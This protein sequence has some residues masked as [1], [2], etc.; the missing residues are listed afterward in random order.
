[1]PHPL[2]IIHGHDWTKL[3]KHIKDTIALLAIKEG[4]SDTEVE[5]L[6]EMYVTNI[7]DNHDNIFLASAVGIVQYLNFYNVFPT[8]GV[9]DE[10]KG[11]YFTG[12]A[13]SEHLEKLGLA[14]LNKFHLRAVL[15]ILDYRLY[16]PY[17]VNRPLLTERIRSV[18]DNNAIKTHLGKYGWYL[19]YKCLYNAA[20]EKSKT[21]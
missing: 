14:D 21:L 19:I 18:I 15:R 4:R 13:I 9:H 10:F 11:V 12:I 8:E 1:M 7:E 16:E 5:K 20:N 3:L 2:V 17:R 6:I